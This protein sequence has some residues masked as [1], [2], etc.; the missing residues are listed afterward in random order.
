MTRETQSCFYESDDGL[1]LHYLDF[2]P[3]DDGGRTPAVCLPGLTRSANDFV[4]LGKALAFDAAKPRR[5]VAFDYRGRGLSDHDPD[6]HN[7][8]L[9]VER[10]DVLK[11]LALC[12]IEAA[13]FIGTS[14]GGLHILA[15]AATNRDIIRAAVF[16][17]IGPVLEPDGLSRIKSYI[18]AMATP[19]TFDGAVK[20]LKRGAGMHF[21]GLSDREWRVF[22]T[23]TFG[24]DESN[25]HLRYD[26]RLAQTFDAID[27]GSPLPESWDLFD[28][29]EG[30]PVLT[31]RGANS[32]LL[33]SETLSEMSRRWPGCETMTVAGQGHAPLLADKPTLA[34][35]RGFLRKADLGENMST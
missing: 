14:R 35:I 16:N 10:A 1:K 26:P 3:D 6:W 22:T 29:L 28:K 30:A 32:D 20:L 15:L 7:Y 23:T 21:D 5:V 27:L 18:G 12:G 4:I 11:G 19:R 13:N 8:N 31:I 2:I 17:D 25:L 9:A 34:R 24:I 33:S